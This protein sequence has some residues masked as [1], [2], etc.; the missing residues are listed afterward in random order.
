M[1]VFFNFPPCLSKMCWF[2]QI[3]Y[4][5]ELP[6]KFK[7]KLGFPME[8]E[9]DSTTGVLVEDSFVGGILRDCTQ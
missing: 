8:V 5:V 6:K 7:I 1:V 4:I 3:L 2:W 9:A